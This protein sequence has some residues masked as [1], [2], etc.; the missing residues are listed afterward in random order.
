MTKKEKINEKYHANVSPFG[1]A[2]MV[3]RANLQSHKTQFFY[4]VY[5]I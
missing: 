3:K 4:S 5:Y 1:P 2:S